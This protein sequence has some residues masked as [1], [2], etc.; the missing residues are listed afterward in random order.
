MMVFHMVGS[1]G[2]LAGVN[3][4]RVAPVAGSSAANSTS[5]L[6]TPTSNWSPARSGSA[7]TGPAMVT[8]HFEAPSFVERAWT[9]PASLVKYTM[10]TPSAG[11][12]TTGP[13]T[14]KDQSGAPFE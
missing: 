9:D 1:P 14:S 8:T 3:V 12:E 11:E 10:S 13:P 2:Y 7:F 4:Q 6:L 5:P